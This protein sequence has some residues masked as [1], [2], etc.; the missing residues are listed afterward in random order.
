MIQ[1]IILDMDG[2]IT[3]PIIDFAALRAELGVPAES[4]IVAHIESL[5]EA[6]AEKAVSV[7]TAVEREAA[8]AST[9]NDG[10]G[11]LLEALAAR[12]IQTALV[13]NN[14]RRAMEYIVDKHGLRFDAMLSRN[15]GRLKPSPDLI[16]KAMAALDLTADAVVGVGDGRYDA[17]ACA[18]AG[19]R[20]IH[21]TNG[22]STLDHDPRVDRLTD[23]IPL[24]ETLRPSS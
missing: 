21:L 20:F 22:D 19:V 9:L 23:V 17:E 12:Q 5:A 16:Q 6:E 18:A 3:E 24:L 11:D 13:T 1:G 8:E 14:H 2:T 15:D 4:T 7:L 10:V